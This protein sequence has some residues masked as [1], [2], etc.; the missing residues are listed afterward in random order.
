MKIAW[1]TT[2]I[3]VCLILSIFMDSVLMYFYPSD[4]FIDSNLFNFTKAGLLNFMIFI[5]FLIISVLIHL[6]SISIYL[7]KTIKFLS[8]YISILYLYK[9][10]SLIMFSNNDLQI[11]ECYIYPIIGLIAYLIQRFAYDKRSS[12][13]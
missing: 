2:G 11:Q 7:K 5:S 9:S 4:N 1:V 8:L 3:I 6:I 12:N 13:I 10:V